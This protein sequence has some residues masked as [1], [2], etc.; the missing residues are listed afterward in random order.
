MIQETRIALKNAGRINPSSIEDY[1]NSGGF[2][3]FKMALSMDP[4][5]V[6]KEMKNSGLRG[7]GGGGFPS[8]KKLEFTDQARCHK[9]GPKF[10][11][12]NAD[13]GE[14]GTYKDRIIMEQDPYIMLEGMLISA[15]SIWA[16]KGYIYIRREYTESI[17]KLEQAIKN[18]YDQGYLGENIQGSGF[19]LDIELKIGAGSYLCGEELT[20]LESLEGKRG[21]PRIKPPF[22][23]NVGVFGQ[24]T[25]INNVETFSNIPYIITEGSEAY[26]KMGTERSPGTKIF[27]ISGDIENPGTY[28]VEMGVTLK[29]LI[30]ELAGGMKNGKPFKAA[31]LG[32]AAG[33]FVNEEAFDIPMGFDTLKEIGAILGSGAIMVMDETRSLYDMMHSILEFFEHESCGKCVPCRVGTRMLVMMLKDVKEKKNGNRAEMLEKMKEEAEYMQKTSLCPLGGSPILPIGSA[34]QYFKDEF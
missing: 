31:I 4:R 16:E 2:K 27:T 23:A 14:P 19:S 34:V 32:G 26:K 20:L 28:E 12:C 1:M 10:I 18:C 22:P 6:I 7:R 29:Q 11:V 15:Y 33:T 25:L 9:C 3:A 21:Y 13:E 30:Y 5:N 17:Q 8:G 24:P